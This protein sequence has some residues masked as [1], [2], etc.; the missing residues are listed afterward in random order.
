MLEQLGCGRQGWAGRWQVP[1]LGL[2]P[3]TGGSCVSWMGKT[4]RIV[5]E[6]CREQ[7]FWPPKSGA[8]VSGA[9][10]PG[11]GCFAGAG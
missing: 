3:G 11:G 6:S 2:S 10:S 7:L 1:A 5:Q 9:Q 8:L 4:S